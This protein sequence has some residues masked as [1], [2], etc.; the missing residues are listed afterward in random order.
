[1]SSKEKNVEKP[2][3]NLKYTIYVLVGL[4]FMFVFGRVVPTWSTVTPMGV[5]IIGIFLGMLFL[6]NTCNDVIFPCML[7][8][9]AV[10]T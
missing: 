4:F 5:N 8:L 3:L 1:M 6:T 7:G 10:I 9:I 2:A